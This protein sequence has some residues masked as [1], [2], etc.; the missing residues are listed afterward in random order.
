LP[1]GHI[2]LALGLFSVGVEIGHFSF[3]GVV[4][5]LIAIIRRWS[6]QFPTWAQVLPA[7]AIGGIAAYWV[8]ERIAAF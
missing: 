7:Y 2:P 3:V 5:A 8:I 6:L 1:T 4:L